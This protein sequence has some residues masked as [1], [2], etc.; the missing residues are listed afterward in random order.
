MKYIYYLRYF[1]YIA[2]NWNLRLAWFTVLQ[3]MKGEKKYGINTIQLNDLKKLTLK[4]D[5]NQAEIYQGANYYLLELMFEKLQTLSPNN[6]II[7]FGSGKGRVLVVAAFYDFIKIT[8]VEFGKE[9]C[10]EARKTI[11]G[12]QQKFPG[13]I[14][15]VIYANAV[16]YKIEDDSNVF[17]FFNPFNEISML[18]V[19][20]NILSSL[21]KKLRTVYVIYINPLHKEIFMSAG[22]EEIYFFEKL[23][24]IQG[25][26]LV[27]EI[28]KED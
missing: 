17:F 8:G 10:I 11:H 12:V 24:Y 7:D 21:K 25:S 22:F 6:Y 2:F 15:N 1:F 3:E 16:D 26:L 9:L 27:K 23:F 19:V 13:K 14:F 4:G 18:A 20:K 5:I 28:E